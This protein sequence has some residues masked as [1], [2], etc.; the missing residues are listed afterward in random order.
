V[1]NWYVVYPEKGSGCGNIVRASNGELLVM[2]AGKIMRS[3]DQGRTWSD[4]EPLPTD[5][6]YRRIPGWENGSL[7][8]TRED[9]LTLHLIRDKPP[10]QIL[11]A[12]SADNGKT[13]SDPVQT[14]EVTFPPEK[15][16]EELYMAPMLELKDGTLLMFAYCRISGERTIIEGRWYDA[17]TPPVVSN[18]CLRSTDGGQS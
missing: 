7:Y 16:F 4:P 2:H 9:L 13:W 3:S 10:F 15:P 8:T 14:G 1:R 5:G 6:R 17:H 12:S 18:I 11:R